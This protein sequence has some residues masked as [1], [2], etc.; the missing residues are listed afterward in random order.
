MKNILLTTFFAL[1]ITQITYAQKQDIK[2][3]YFDYL[4]V[5]MDAD[6]KPEAKVKAIALLQRSSEL[7]KTQLGNVTYHLGRLYEE[8]GEIEKAVPYYEESIK[9]TP[10]YYVPYR[11]LGFMYYKKCVALNQKLSGID[12]AKDSDGYKKALDELKKSSL[13]T[14]K[15]LEKSQACDPDDETLAMIKNLYK[16]MKDDK[17]LAT[18]S[19]RLKA[20]SSDCVTLLED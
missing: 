9:I 18:I 13:K 6:E 10:G 20:L 7:T 16:N 2:D 12:K 5:R 14:A 17:A 3:L 19:D 15:Y 1:L 4:Q 8:D 11:A